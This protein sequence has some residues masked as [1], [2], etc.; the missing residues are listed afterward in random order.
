MEL[1]QLRS[2]AAVAELGQLTRAAEK[3]HVSQPAVSAQIKAL[4]DELG[5]ALFE[6]TPSG[7]VL[8]S[9]GRALL[10]EA[11]NLVAAAQ[12]LRSHARSIR[13]E[14]VGRVRVGTVADPEFVRVGDF[15]ARA[16][17]E[18]PLLEIE[19]HHA[20]TGVAFEQVRDGSL[21]ASFYYGGQT[22]PDVA[23]VPLRDYYYR[24]VLPAAWGDRV[25]QASW[26]EIVAMPWIL[27]PPISSLRQLAEELFTARGSSPVS[28]VEA[29]NEAVIRSLVVAGSG[30]A[31]MRE[32]LANDALAAGEL[33]LWSSERLETTL[34]FLYLRRREDDPEIR[35]LLDV[36]RRVWASARA[37]KRASD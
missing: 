14:V 37:P 23:A 7:M 28:R 2:F 1:Y 8:T 34:S 33:V 29:D 10:P 4:E 6:R 31:L 21:D 35:A 22:H 3:L 32:D 20:V 26:D 9:A 24:I 12:A 18:Y 36:L 25:K 19:L 27:A 13:G 15:L 5:V 11:E 30:A 16:L 17:E